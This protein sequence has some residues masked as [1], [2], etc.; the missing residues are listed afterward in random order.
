MRSFLVLVLALALEAPILAQDESTI[1]TFEIPSVGG[2]AMTPDLVTLI[3]SSPET[4]ELYFVDTITGQAPRAVRVP[5]KPDR[6]ALQGDQLFV[7]VQGSTLVYSLDAK[8][9]KTLRRYELPG[10]AIQNLACH[11]VKGPVFASNLDEEVVSLDSNGS[12]VRKTQARGMFLSIDPKA[13]RY[14]YTAT[15]RPSRDVIEARRGARGTVQLQLVTV[16]ETAAVLKYE[17]GTR[18]LRLV[19]GNPNTAVGA[20]GYLHVSPDG[21]R[22]AMVAGGGW[23]ST[24]NR[25]IRYDVAVFETDDMTTMLGGLK[26]GAPQAI[27]FHPVLDIGVAQGNSTDFYTF[28]A[29]SLIHRGQ[30][31]VTAGGPVKFWHNLLVFCAKGTKVATLQGNYLHLIPLELTESE[32][33]KLTKK[34]GRLPKVT[35][36]TTRKVRST[37]SPQPTRRRPTAKSRAANSSDSKP[38][39]PL[40]ALVNAP[41]WRLAQAGAGIPYLIDRTHVLARV[42]KDIAGGSLLVRPARDARAWLAPDRLKALRDGKVFVALL[43]RFNGQIAVPRQTLRKLKSAGWKAEAKGF[44]AQKRLLDA[45]VWEW[46]LF[47]HKVS[48]GP[49]DLS[50]EVRLAPPTQAVFFFK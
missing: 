45:E 16:A 1:A 30:R 15:N 34:L 17:I 47:S 26:C 33:S 39:P 21:Q 27:C 50:M 49:L 8:T 32:L 2:W 9:G 5:F 36:A 12:Q 38:D 22:Y 18:T 6:I 43:V 7:S 31:R 23:R 11:P 14:L 3:L 46:Q 48:K 20:G 19:G 25:R 37:Q 13:G 44:Q 42:P 35:Q 29:R 41:N 40:V 24:T 4:G 28:D 10:T